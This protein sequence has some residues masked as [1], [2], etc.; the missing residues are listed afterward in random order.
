VSRHPLNFRREDPESCAPHLGGFSAKTRTPI[1]FHVAKDRVSICGQ[2]RFYRPLVSL[3][4]GRGDEVRLATFRVPRSKMRP[5]DFCFPTLYV[6][7]PV[8]ACSR[9]DRQMRPPEG[10]RTAC[11]QWVAPIATEESNVSRRSKR[12]GGSPVSTRRYRPRESAS[13]FL[14]AIRGDLPSDTPVASLARSVHSAFVGGA[15]R[16]EGCQIVS[17]SVP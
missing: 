5:T 11:T 8:P 1:R 6:R 12:F 4:L 16:G 13:G 15:R 3:E 9:L 7:V 17:A 10:L 14:T 2:F